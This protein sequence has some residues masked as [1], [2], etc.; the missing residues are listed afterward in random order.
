MSRF[1]QRDIYGFRFWKC[2]LHAIVADPVSG[3][4][5]HRV[6]DHATKASE[7]IGS[8]CFFKQVHLGYLFIQRQPSV[9]MPSGISFRG[10][11]LFAKARRAGILI[12]L[13]ADQ[14]VIDLVKHRS[15]AVVGQ[16]EAVTASKLSSLTVTFGRSVL[17]E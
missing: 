3:A 10:S 7:F 17:G 9:L 4:G 16:L 6:V 12:T 11:I 1:R 8:P 13:V 5:A 15:A 14:A 2:S